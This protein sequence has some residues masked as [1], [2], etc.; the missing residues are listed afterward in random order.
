MPNKDFV[1]LKNVR[2][3]FPHLFSRPIINGD[4]GK[5]GGT[6]L[7][8]PKEH[9]KQI[10]AV[11]AEIDKLV[12]AKFKGKQLPSDKLCLRDG[13]QSG[14][15]EYDGYTILSANTNDKPIVVSTN[16]KGVVAS[17]EDCQIY[18]GCRV[19]AK[20][21]LWAQDNKY[22]KRVNAQLVAIQFAADDEALD[23]AHVSVDEAMDGFGASEDG[24]DF[25][26]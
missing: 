2:V 8:D 22:G 6:F 14:R 20:I 9:K 11:Q 17:E 7:L 13:D 15:D 21:N 16:G 19:N 12:K 26:D 25:L 24:D 1:M 5:F 3:S 10:E 4:E 23:G 18:A